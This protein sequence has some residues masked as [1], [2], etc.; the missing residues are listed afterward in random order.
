MWCYVLLELYCYIIAVHDYP[1]LM[2]I[3]NYEQLILK[4]HRL[5]AYK[6][7]DISAMTVAFPKLKT[8]R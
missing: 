8:L 4:K 2:L 6:F 5:F 1:H 3:H 7:I